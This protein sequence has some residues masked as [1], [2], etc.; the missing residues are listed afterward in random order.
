MTDLSVLQDRKCFHIS[1]LHL[2]NYYSY[3]VKIGCCSRNSNYFLLVNEYDDSYESPWIRQICNFLNPAEIYNFVHRIKLDAFR[4]KAI[5][6]VRKY[7]KFHLKTRVWHSHNFL[8]PNITVEQY[9]IVNITFIINLYFL[10]FVV[11][12]LPAFI[13]IVY[14]FLP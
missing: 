2:K 8:L 5:P 12:E 3:R 14:T 6:A 13:R 1:D 11:H 4:Q 10:C 7:E 9:F